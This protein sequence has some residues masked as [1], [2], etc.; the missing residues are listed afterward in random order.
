MVMKEFFLEMFEYHHHFNL[1][2]IGQVEL[3][4]EALPQRSFPLLCHVLNASYVWNSRILLLPSPGVNQ[5][6]TF[7]ECRQMND[8]I[9]ND[10]QAILKDRDLDEIIQY[11]NFA[12]VEFAN[13]IR[14]IL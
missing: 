14:D 7:N 5:M 1:L 13:S 10:V 11:K 12:G 9:F 2:L 3:H 8:A 6:H 4:K